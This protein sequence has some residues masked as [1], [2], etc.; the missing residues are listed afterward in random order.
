MAE[1]AKTITIVVTCNEPDCDEKVTYRRETVHGFKS[2]ARDTK[3]V[4]VYL[5]C[6]ADHT[7]KYQFEKSS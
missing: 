5:T 2:T 3:T 6:A 4:S 1:T 7:H